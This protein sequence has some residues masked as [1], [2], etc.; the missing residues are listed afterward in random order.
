MASEFPGSLLFYEGT[1]AQCNSNQNRRELF[2]IT[3]T[4]TLRYMDA[5]GNYHNFYNVDSV[6]D[7]I[8][9]GDIHF[10]I[11]EID[12]GSISGINDDDHIQYILVNGNRG[13]THTISGVWPTESGHLTN[14]G[15]VDSA[16]AEASGITDHGLLLGLTDDD[17]PIYSLVDGSRPFTGTISGVLP[18]ESGHLATKGYIDDFVLATS[19][20]V[21]DHGFLTGLT[22]DDHPQYTLTDGTRDFTGTVSGIIP[23]ESGHL[24]TKGY[25]DDIVGA[26][27]HGALTGLTDDDHPQYT[28]V[29]GS[30]P[31]TG[32]V[33]GVI[34][35]E[36]AHLTTKAYVDT[37]VLVASGSL[38]GYSGNRRIQPN[39]PDDKITTSGNLTT[40]MA[41]WTVNT[42]THG[43]SS[44]NVYAQ[45]GIT[46]QFGAYG[47]AHG[48][49][50]F[51][52][53][54]VL[55]GDPRLM[56]YSQQYIHLHVSGIAASDKIVDIGADTVDI[57]GYL[58]LGNGVPVNNIV[59]SA[60]YEDTDTC[61]W[62]GANIIDYV[63]SQSGISDHTLLSNIGTT[64]HPDL[65]VHVGSGEIHIH[66]GDIA[67]SG[68]WSDHVYLSGQ[69]HYEEGSID[70][71]NILNIGTITHPDIDVHIGSGEIHTHIDLLSNSGDWSDHVY[72]SGQV[73]FEE[74]SIDHANIQN[75]GTTTH[76]DLDAHYASG[77]IHTHIDL[78]SNSGN[79]N[80]AYDH[81]IADGSSHSFIDQDLTLYS[82]PTFSGLY[83]EAITMSSG[84]LTIQNINLGGG[85][86]A[87]VLN[88]VSLDAV[89]GAT[90]QIETELQYVAL[91]HSNVALAGS[92][93][94]LSRSRG[95][96]A[97]PLLVENGDVIASLDAAAYDGTDYVLAGQIDFEVD[98]V[99]ASN[100]MP[101]KILF[102][103]TEAGGIL[104]TSRWHIGSDGHLDADA[105]YN[106]TTTGSITGN[107]LITA[108]N[109]GIVGDL[110]IIQ[111]TGANTLLVN[112]TTQTTFLG[113]G[114]AP[115][116]YYGCYINK[117]YTGTTS[118]PA[119]AYCEMN[120]NPA[121]PSTVT[122]FGIQFRAK[123]GGTQNISGDVVGADFSTWL[124]GGSGNLDDMYCQRAFLYGVNT[125]KIVTGDIAYAYWYSEHTSP[126]V[127]VNGNGYQL[128]MA[129]Y[130][131]DFTIGGTAYGIKQEGDLINYFD[132]QTQIA[133]D[134]NGLVLGAG[135]DAS[136]VYSGSHMVF[137]SQLVGTGGFQFNNGNMGVGVAPNAG[138][139]LYSFAGTGAAIV[140]G[141]VGKTSSTAAGNSGMEGY[142]DGAG[143]TNRGVY[144]SATNASNNYHFE[145]AAGNYST[146]AAGGSWVDAACTLNKKKDIEDISDTEM[147]KI[148]SVVKNMRPIKYKAKLDPEKELVGFALDEGF[149]ECAIDRDNEGKITG[150]M[151]GKLGMY[152]LVIIRNL[153]ER[154]EAL[155]NKQ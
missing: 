29:D 97:A 38:W 109:I 76:L 69:V 74:G 64:T 141:I 137:D 54:T 135:Q 150:Y 70:H 28:L 134:T 133:S 10:L 101:G 18:T 153:I 24:A 44:W 59:A 149:P 123:L 57:N 121:A 132:G 34:P 116:D 67:N 143:I 7:H 125:A 56:I 14:K 155:E 31:F 122:V 79:W 47:L 104:P 53:K 148:I 6:T 13:F 22:D 5:G 103:T 27:D 41:N 131:S 136:I 111:F 92:R 146:S 124:N 99:A 110:D 35:T 82:H 93:F 73:H 4:N 80:D 87:F 58:M 85:L 52:A 33:S 2:Y 45:H 94:M 139:K 118:N 21:T 144:G 11:T 16:V 91:Q 39:T 108:S 81:I 126:A 107:S 127:T 12:H 105:A 145:D 20:G 119:A 89:V 63:I 78:L 8:A 50:E 23:T 142:A 26:S 19:S 37:A 17:H 115:T 83:A 75:I 55:Y 113:I 120:Y 96:L 15:Y 25:V 129:D 71:A 61:L 112:G 88:G 86:T 40:A 3:D 9:S 30:R 60:L 36:A 66:V 102:K 117:I 32:A 77:E 95:T 90:S 68:D 100:D 72:N 138:R 62:T 128:L 43:S 114:V 65:D 154:I 147:N 140:V 98:G 84:V 151:G 152:N 42:E 51:A 106:I 49:A 130:S 48:T 46:G 1:L